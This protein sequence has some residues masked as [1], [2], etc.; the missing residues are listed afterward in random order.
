MYIPL[1]RAWQ[2]AFSVQLEHMHLALRCHRRPILVSTDSSAAAESSNEQAAAI[3]RQWRSLETA[4]EKA[5]K[6]QKFDEAAD[7]QRDLF[8][9]QMDEVYY[10]SMLLENIIAWCLHVCIVFFATVQSMALH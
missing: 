4:R 7:R 8:A 10:K 2:Q 3:E 5:V 1:L 6:L 9:L